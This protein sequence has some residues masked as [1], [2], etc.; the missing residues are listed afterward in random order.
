V[1]AVPVEIASDFLDV[2]SVV[3][4]GSSLPLTGWQRTAAIQAMHALDYRIE[5]IQQALQIERRWYLAR[6]AREEAGIDL[7]AGD[8]QPDL[9]AVEWV[10]AGARLRLRGADRDAAIVALAADGKSAPEIARRIGISST[11]VS[12]AAQRLGVATNAGKNNRTLIA[13]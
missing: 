8:D 5:R 1:T 11:E 7:Y 6:V 13:A 9:L 10:R 3:T 2:A 12:K 4:G